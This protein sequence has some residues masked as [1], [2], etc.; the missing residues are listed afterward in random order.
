MSLLIDSGDDLALLNCFIFLVTTTLPLS[1]LTF[2]EGLTALRCLLVFAGLSATLEALETPR[3]DLEVRSG[4]G[5]G[6]GER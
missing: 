5:G 4:G 6:E 3:S 2:L 1:F